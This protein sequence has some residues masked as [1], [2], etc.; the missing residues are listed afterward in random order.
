MKNTVYRYTIS[1]AK[2]QDYR[3]LEIAVLNGDSL[4]IPTPLRR[5]E[6]LGGMCKAVKEDTLELIYE[7]WEID[8]NKFKHP[9]V[10]SYKK[11]QIEVEPK[12]VKLP[13]G[14]PKKTNWK[15]P[16]RGGGI[17]HK[18]FDKQST[19]DCY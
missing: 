14:K 3:N 7:I 10:S 12:V 1:G 5:D 11:V 9:S 13:P 4:F 2:A 6:V 8:E 15:S 19:K 16:N 17:R 18:N